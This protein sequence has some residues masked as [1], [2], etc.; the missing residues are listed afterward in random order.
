MNKIAPWILPAAGVVLLV[1]SIIVLASVGGGT[2]SV[3]EAGL[4]A[5]IDA[6]RRSLDAL[7]ETD[8]QLRARVASLERAIQDLRKAVKRAPGAPQVVPEPLPP[9][10]QVVAPFDAGLEDW[11]VP[12]WGSGTVL[13]TTRPGMFRRGEGALALGYT[14]GEAPP[15]ARGAVSAEGKIRVVRLYARTQVRQ[16][17][18][19]VGV[20]EESGALY[21][22]RVPP[23]RPEHGWRMVS[24]APAA[25]GL[26]RE[27]VDPDNKLDLSKIRAVYVVDRSR[28]AVGGNVLLV[29]D[30]A[31]DVIP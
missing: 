19:A 28:E 25:M 8:V 21:E 22:V 3:D 24:V 31:I 11:A 5:Q 12:E 26:V 9:P 29:D 10:G 18:L 23:L 13:H 7:K 4:R 6:T 14:Y 17:S 2:G 20:E 15:A 1:A 30:V 16:M 27:T